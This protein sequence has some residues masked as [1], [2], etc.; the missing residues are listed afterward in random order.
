MYKIVLIILNLIGIVGGT[1][2]MYSPPEPAVFFYCWG[3]VVFLI[4]M[5]GMWFTLKPK[6]R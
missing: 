6:V 4:G 2:L 1:F 3:L 5:V